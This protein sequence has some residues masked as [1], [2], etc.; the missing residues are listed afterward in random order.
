MSLVARVERALD[1]RPRL[2][3]A[4]V[5]TAA[6]LQ[7]ALLAAAALAHHPLPVLSIALGATR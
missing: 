7:A 2:R 4:L 3:W 1:A 5:G 6:L